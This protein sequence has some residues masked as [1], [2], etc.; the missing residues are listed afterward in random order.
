MA[1]R[2]TALWFWICL[3]IQPRTEGQAKPVLR[4]TDYPATELFDGKPKKIVWPADL[5]VNDPHNEKLISAVKLTLPRNSNFAGHYAIVEYS[6]GSSCHSMVVIDMKTGEVFDNVPF[7]ALD[8]N[9]DSRD[10]PVYKGLA[11][12]KQSRLLVASGCFDFDQPES[13]HE[14]GTKY[15]EFKSAQF[16]VLEFSRGPV[17]A[18]LQ[19]HD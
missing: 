11:F 1:R 10:G 5:D 15:F 3:F 12:K 8:V 9:L 16:V 13:K 7:S 14:C 2:L 6:C 19:K 18:R 4:F 17:F